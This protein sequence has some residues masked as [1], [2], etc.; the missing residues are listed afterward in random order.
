MTGKLRK[1]LFGI[2]TDEAS[3]KARGFTADDR[4]TQALLEKVGVTFI[5]GYHAALLE[6]R[7]EA[8]SK[9]LAEAGTEHV[10]FAFEGAAMGLALLEIVFPWNRQRWS[11]YVSTVGA[12][13]IYMVH[14][15]AGFALARMKRPLEPFL[16]RVDPLLG[17]LAAD[18]YGFH[19]GFFRT[20]RTIVK[21]LRPKRIRGYAAKVY[22][23]GVGRSIWFYCGANAKRI[24]KVIGSF[25]PA[26]QADMIA[27][28]GLA[29]GYAG[30]MDRSEIEK[31]KE[32]AGDNL[33]CF[34][35]GVAFAAKARERAGNV[36]GNTRMVAEAVC[37]MTVEEAASLTD[38]GLEELKPEG[39]LPAYEVWRRRIQSRFSR[40]P[41]R[42]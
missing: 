16:S 34:A 38:Q 2:S 5:E 37:S 27:G 15:G 36:T 18:G 3:F 1:A 12:P 7:P 8:L 21:Q 39:D 10:G 11:E 19:D 4:S 30:G 25:D 32:M 29:C 14:V 28:I 41:A 17:W 22:D 35:Q 13:H 24:M 26:R 9:R 40:A 33:A 31:L 23:Q 20:E 42:P 6:N